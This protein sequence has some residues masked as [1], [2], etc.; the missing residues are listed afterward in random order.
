MEFGKTWQQL[1][2]MVIKFHHLK[3]GKNLKLVKM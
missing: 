3:P 1:N 2:I